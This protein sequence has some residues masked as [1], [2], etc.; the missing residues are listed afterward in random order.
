MDKTKDAE[1]NLHN[2][3]EAAESSFLAV[4]TAN[5][6]HFYVA[7]GSRVCSG[8]PESRQVEQSK[9]AARCRSKQTRK[10][11]LKKT[12]T[13]KQLFAI[14]GRFVLRTTGFHRH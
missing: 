6:L 12:T 1:G 13:K 3:G 11:L 7:E 14:S 5:N 10:A 9:S 2:K 4:L 8:K